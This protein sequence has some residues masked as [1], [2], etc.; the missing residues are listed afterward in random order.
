MIAFDGPTL[1]HFYFKKFS[2]GLIP[3]RWHGMLPYLFFKRDGS[4]TL[5]VWP[6]FRITIHGD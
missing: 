6:L 2:F 4:I 5:N 1:V 3:R